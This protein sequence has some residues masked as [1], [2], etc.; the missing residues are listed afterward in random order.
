MAPDKIYA[1]E[2][3]KGVQYFTS[4][5]PALRPVETYIRKDALLEWAKKMI[6]DDKNIGK[7]GGYYDLIDKLE[8]M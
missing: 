2:T 6:A 7:K 8:S 5:I 1:T 3:E 4:G